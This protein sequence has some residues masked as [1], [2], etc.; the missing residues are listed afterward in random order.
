MSNIQN[1]GCM[2]LTIGPYNI[3]NISAY[4]SIELNVDVRNAHFA[5][6]EET[7]SPEK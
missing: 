3:N 4:A 1:A 2:R 6:K 7:Q 5:L